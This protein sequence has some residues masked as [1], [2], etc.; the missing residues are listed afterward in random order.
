[1][2]QNLLEELANPLE[3]GQRR[4][5]EFV[6]PNFFVRNPATKDIRVVPRTK[7]YGLVFDKRV[8]DPSTFKSYPYG[9]MADLDETDMVNV[10]ALLDL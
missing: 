4:N 1:M 2:K 8:V 3:N 10:N 7:Q 9:Y 6:N 5:V